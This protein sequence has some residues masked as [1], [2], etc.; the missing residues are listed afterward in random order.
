MTVAS[1]G[2][3]ELRMRRPGRYQRAT[4]FCGQAS[5]PTSRMRSFGRSCSMVAS[6]VGQH[7]IT[8][9]LRSR[10]KSASSSPIRRSPGRAGNERRARDQRHPDL[11]DREIEG[12]GHALVDAVARLIAVKLGR[13]AHEIADARRARS[14]RPSG[15][16]SFPR[17]R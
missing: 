17:C 7:A 2:P 15:C 14:Q 3:Y 16:R 11:L 9:T 13:N 6:K 12:D 10:R 8:V 1:V 4:R 5:P